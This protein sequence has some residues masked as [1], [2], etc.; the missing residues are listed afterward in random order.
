VAV[1]QDW[2]NREFMQT[3]QTGVAQ[4]ASFLN[5]FG[6]PAPHSLRFRSVAPDTARPQADPAMWLW[7]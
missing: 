7:P 3:V 2:A 5:D 4:L 1:Q 6:A